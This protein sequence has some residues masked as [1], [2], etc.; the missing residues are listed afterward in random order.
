MPEKLPI[1]DVIPEVR[2]K[3]ASGNTL[4]LQAPPGAGKSTILPIELLSEPWLQGQKIL[5]LEP[6]RLAARAV[7]NRMAD[8]LEEKVGE[9]V[10]YRIR[11]ENKVGP[12]TRIEVLTEGILTRILQ[13]D[14]AL[15]GV[16]LV[17]FDEFHERS[18][19][20]DLALV[21]CR[22]AQSVLR[23]D[24]RILIMSATLDGQNLSALMGNAP[25]VSSQGRQYPVSLKYVPQ[26]NHIP[27]PVQV[28]KAVRKAVGTEEGDILV[29]LP[30]AGE[31]NRVQELLE[32]EL[33]GMRILP[34]Y[35]D[36][37]PQKQ[38]EA[39]LP[40]PHGRRKIILATS[41]AETSLTIEGIRVVV[42]SGYSRVPRFD[43]RSGFTR[44]ETVAVTLDTADQRAGRAG[45]L[46]PGMAYRLW[47]EGAHIHLNAHRKPEIMEADLAPMMLELANWGIQDVHSL[48][49]VTQPP[50]GAV[51]Q[52]MAL[53]SELDAICDGRITERGKEMLRLPTHPRIAHMLLEGRDDSLLALAADVAAL[54]EEKDPLPKEAGADFTLRV[55]ALRRWRAGERVNAS[56]NLLERVE[57]LA[58][59]WRR[60]FKT[61]EEN[62]PGKEYETGKLL[63]AAY[64]ER[65][66]R[67][68]PD[69]RYRLSVGSIA[70]LPEHDA[71]AKEDWLVA[72]SMDAG[73]KEAKIFLAA[74]LS[75]DD[76]MHLAKE[77]SVLAW[78]E[79]KGELIARNEVRIGSIL[80]SS[81]PL[82]NILVEEKIQVLCQAVQ[83]EGL[84]ILNWDDAATQWQA[85]LNSV[86]Q[87]RPAE[88]WPD[89]SDA[90]LLETVSE[91]L[92]PYLEAVRSRQ[93]FK[94]LEVIPILENILDWPQRQRLDALAPAAI[95]VPSGSMIRLEYQPDGSAPVLAV[96]LQEM[97][98]LLETPT[99]NEGRTKVLLHLLSPGFK[100]VQVTQ[101]LKSFWQNTYPEV[102]KE[103]RI[104]YPRHSWPEDPWTAEA[105]RGAKKRM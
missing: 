58:A 92:G 21:L 48:A 20:A 29:F 70:R 39:I 53:L 74:P 93:D 34:L 71:L 98:G 12:H 88:N 99:V 94:K 60:L 86:H 11:F 64:P 9:R 51:K 83:R 40:D 25:I 13:Q 36:L 4:I 104:R 41:I 45:R 47:S 19:N 62:A 38:Q 33:G 84:R 6:R 14:N 17:I 3:L 57:R 2:E 96:R 68:E 91:W 105:V 67:R 90:H 43:A 102:R 8:L 69:G 30:G 10:G 73:A 80:V 27:L 22:E 52:A 56:R 78:D 26:E 76:I 101:D 24:L 89:V 37:N 54:L 95:K 100:P 50:N 85:R 44:L 1:Y 32:A 63:A 97:F 18:L 46:G 65:I 15:E 75:P 7:A 79:Q 23:E 59:N 87:W 31:I 5:M 61:T 77:Q 49:W 16:G 72:A 103:L 82:K 35:G 42:D 66:A 55:D 81:T 28:A